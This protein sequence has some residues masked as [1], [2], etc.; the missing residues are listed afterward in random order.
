MN[1]NRLIPV[2][3]VNNTNKIFTVRKGWPLAKIE[4][5]ECQTITSVSQ[6]TNLD[7]RQTHETFNDVDVPVEH[8]VE[9]VNLL[10]ANADLFALKD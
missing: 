9:V 10:K 5:I 7:G 2:L 3:L 1:Q 8:R 6:S 4:R